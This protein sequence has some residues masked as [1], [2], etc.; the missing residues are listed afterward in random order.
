[1]HRTHDE[2]V[3]FFVLLAHPKPSH[4]DYGVIDGA[5]VAC[6]VNEPTEELAEAV[7]REAIEDLEWDVEE[8]DQGYEVGR[9]DF[10]DGSKSLQ[11]FDQALI[12]DCVLDF[13]R[14][15]VGAPDDD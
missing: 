13:N 11:R 15:R 10:E 8:R 9:D 4:R 7:A 12:D 2:R 6:W 5:Y 1:M 3:Y 14:W